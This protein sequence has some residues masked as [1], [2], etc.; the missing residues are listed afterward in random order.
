MNSDSKRWVTL[1]ASMIASMCAGFA[2]AWSIFL[3]PLISAFHWS[4]ADVSISFTLIMSMAAVTAIFA[5]KA[6]DYL[7]PRQLILLGGALFGGGIAGMGFISS[8]HQLY[9]CALIAGVGLGTVYPGGTMSNSVRFFPDK[10]GLASGLLTAGYGVGPVIWAP[11]SVALISNYD[12]FFTLKVLGAV[13][14]VVIGGVSL[15][16]ST[17]PDNYRHAGWTPPVQLSQ[18]SSSIEKNWR[19]MLRDPLFYFV[20]SA[21]TLGEMSGMMLVGHASPIA[22]EVANITPQAAAGIIGVLAMSN[23]SGRVCWGWISDKLGRYAVVM[24]LFA[25][26]GMGMVALSYVNEYFYLTCAIMLIGLCYGGFL[27][28]MA[29]LTA[30]LFGTKNLGLNFGIMFLTIAVAAYAGPLLVAVIKASSG[31]YTKAFIAAAFINL[32]GFCIFGL[33]ILYKNRLLK[34]R[35]VNS[36]ANC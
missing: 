6:L 4:P 28:L 20:A 27:A 3:K 14:F 25:L 12:V 2:Y 26:G 33:F 32:V 18:Q 9:A 30:D 15:T 35:A 24:V 34:T 1:V 8:L 36:P 13:F 19:Q 17:A 31:S 22:Q 10:R 29:P 16:V 11:I 21:L 5:G 23:T 7:K